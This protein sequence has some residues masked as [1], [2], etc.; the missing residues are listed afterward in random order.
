MKSLLLKDIFTLTR[1]LRIFLL[2]LLI[3]A[4]IPGLDLAACAVVYAAFLP[5]SAVAYD[6]QSKWDQLAVMMPYNPLQLVFSKYLLGYLACLAAALLSLAA[7]FVYTAI[8]GAAADPVA[9]LSI[10]VTAGVA[11]LLQAIGLP[12]IFRLGVEKGRFVFLALIVLAITMASR[13]PESAAIPLPSGSVLVCAGIVLLVLI[14]V[15]SIRLSMR[16]FLKKVTQ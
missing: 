15:V 11:V 7:C 8:T 5:I 14:N 10:P 1:Q 4:L 6:E 3:F 16:F 2:L 13:L 9:Y 12:A